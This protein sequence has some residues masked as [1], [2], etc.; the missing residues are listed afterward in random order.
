MEWAAD[1]VS[2]PLIGRLLSNKRHADCAVGREQAA[3]SNGRVM[4]MK[5]AIDLTIGKPGREGGGGEQKQ[6]CPDWR[7]LSGWGGETGGA[8]DACF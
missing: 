5:S 3:K 6:K 2:V 4:G 8:M 7:G 1:R